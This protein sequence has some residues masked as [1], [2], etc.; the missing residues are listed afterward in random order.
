MKQIRSSGIILYGVLF[1]V[2]ILLHTSL[3]LQG[4]E[5]SET[6]PLPPAG[7]N[8]EEDYNSPKTSTC[9]IRAGTRIVQDPLGSWK[10][11]GSQLLH[12]AVLQPNKQ[13]LAEIV[14]SEHPDIVA[15]ENLVQRSPIAELYAN[16]LQE[17]Q[18]CTG[19]TPSVAEY[20]DILLNPI[21][22]LT[23]IDYRH[24]KAKFISMQRPRLSLEEIRV[25][26]ADLRDS[27]QSLHATWSVSYQGADDIEGWED[28]KFEFWMNANRLR[29]DQSYGDVNARYKR[30]F[31]GNIETV[32]ESD[33]HGNHAVMHAL[34]ST[35]YYFEEN[36]PLWLAKLLDSKKDLGKSSG[37]LENFQNR[38]A[39]PLEEEILFHGVSC[40]PLLEG[41][42]IYYLDPSRNYA[43]RGMVAGRYAFSKEEG[44]LVETPLRAEHFIEQM[45][46][47]GE[48]LWLPV[49]SV[50]TRYFSDRP[51]VEIT[52]EVESLDLNKTIAPKVFNDIVPSGVEIIGGK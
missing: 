36:N 1:F 13:D 26:H 4:E 17:M 6:L 50:E 41:D 40:I 2:A 15:E 30:A 43:C 9:L 19:R 12:I 35:S 11:L 42:T 27:I 33:K 7:F 3:G 24:I 16:Q 23:E 47:C 22:R 18:D 34:I 32:F 14:A 52:V 31:D 48:G 38:F 10:G 37:G 28:G 8:L 45:Q 46:E 44:K 29:Y 25:L 51:P 20:R 39:Y 49:R 21:A 5:A